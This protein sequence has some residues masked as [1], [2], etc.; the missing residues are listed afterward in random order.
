MRLITIVCF[1]LFV[2]STIAA[3]G[4]ANQNNWAIPS[5]V[6]AF[7]LPAIFL[8]GGLATMRKPKE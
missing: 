5:T 3:A 8:V 1:V 6:G 4:I 7:V 2:V